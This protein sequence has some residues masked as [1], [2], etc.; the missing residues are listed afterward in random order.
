MQKVYPFVLNNIRKNKMKTEKEKMLAGEFFH[1][2][3]TELME[4]KKYAR[5]L[6]EKYNHSSEDDL[7]LRYSLL[8]KLFGK[9]GKKILIKPPFHCDYGYQIFVGENFFANFDCVF[10]DAAPIEI[11]DNCM[12]G[13][14][15]CIFAISHPLAPKERQKGIG[16]PKKVTIGNNVWIGGNVTILP[17]ISLGNNVVVGAGSVVTKSFPDNVVIAG[18]PAK[19]IKKI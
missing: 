13:P 15:T 11:G 7:D 14:K 9:C 3:D 1:C 10:L 18:N 12:I 16:I 6:A 19:I 17:G 8:K 5:T 4:N 2:G